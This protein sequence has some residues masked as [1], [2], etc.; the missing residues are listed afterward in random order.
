MTKLLSLLSLN[1][2]KINFCWEQS[3]Q[4]SDAEVQFSNCGSNLNW[5]NRTEGSVPFWFWF[6]RGG[7]GFSSQSG[8]LA[9]IPNR[10]RTGSNRELI[11]VGRQRWVLY[12]MHVWRL[13][14]TGDIFCVTTERWV[15]EKN[16]GINYAIKNNVKVSTLG[17][18][19]HSRRSGRTIEY[20]NAQLHFRSAPNLVQYDKT[21][22]SSCLVHS[23]LSIILDGHHIAL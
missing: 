16:N 8:I 21:S 4:N 12:I 5:Q 23:T 6:G 22:P 17:L 15:Q 1:C 20:K 7:M 19:R 9:R 2:I 14:S 13:Y 11:L 10:C 3:N 18:L